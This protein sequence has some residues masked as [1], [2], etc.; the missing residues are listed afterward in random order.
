[1]RQSVSKIVRLVSPPPLIKFWLRIGSS[2]LVFTASHG[3]F[4]FGTTLSHGEGGFW[5]T[6]SKSNIF[7]WTFLWKYS[8]SQLMFSLI[9]ALQFL[10]KQYE[11]IKSRRDFHSLK[12]GMHICAH[13]K[14]DH[15]SVIRG[16]EIL[17]PGYF[18][19]VWTRL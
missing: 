2:F 8:E 12:P 13:F 6:L 19:S 15:C 9:K 17:T 16:I 7:L 1:M 14:N 4:R 3:F 18:D 10:L 5:V 11:T